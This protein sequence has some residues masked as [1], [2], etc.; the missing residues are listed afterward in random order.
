MKHLAHHLIQC[1]VFVAAVLNFDSPAGF[2]HPNALR[3]SVGSVTQL[4]LDQGD[5]NAF[6]DVSERFKSNVWFHFKLNRLT[7]TAKCNICSTLIKTT[8]G[9][10][11]GLHGHLKKH[12]IVVARYF[13]K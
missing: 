9:S 10:T 5:Q 2:P 12:S 4:E 11:K 1:W 8:R 7:E 13:D 6:E 3:L